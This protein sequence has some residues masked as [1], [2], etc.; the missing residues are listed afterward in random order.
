MN[1]EGD[2]RGI[3]ARIDSRGYKAYQDIKG[4]YR[5]EAFDLF[6]DHVQGD[7]FAAPSR[8][9]ARVSLDRAGFP[10]ILH[11]K[12]IRKI[13]FVDYIARQFRRALRGVVKGQRGMGK[14]G[15]IDI[16]DGGQEILERN[17]VVLDDHWLEARFVV[18]LP[19]MGRTILGR[20][21]MD[22]FFREVPLLVDRALFYRN[23]DSSGV[24][25]HVDAAEDQEYLRGTLPQKGLVAFIGDGA[26]LPR[27]SGVDD[28]PLERNAIPFR[29]PQELEVE[30]ELPNRGRIVGMGIPEGVT[31]IVGG[32]FHGKSTLLNAI[33]RGVYNHIPGDG[34]EVV[35]T[36]PGAVK[37]RAEDGRNIEKVNISAFINNLPLGKDTVKFS[38]ENASGSTS[39][40]ANIIEFLEMGA[41]V[42]LIDEDTSATNFMVRDE[43][44]QELVAK[45]KEPI[46]P[47]VDKVQRLCRDL[48]VSTILVMGGSG[49]YF[50]VADTVIMMDGYMPGCVTQ[51]AKE[52]AERHTTK[53]I[54]EGG[55]TFGTVTP[56]R[57]RIE[58]FDP[59]KGRKEVKIDAKGL[60]TILYGRTAID[61]SY[62]EQLVDRGQTRSIG[63][64]IH[65]YAQHYIHEGLPLREGL[66][67][68]FQDMKEKGLDMLLPY[69][70]GNLARPRIY[71]VAGATNRMRTLR[72]H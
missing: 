62:L 24:K 12:G 4:G 65:Y 29:Y 22:I 21:A 3:L 72:I 11:N 68:C 64:L 5:F 66:E 28:R 38:T 10:P 37:I 52:I 67:R 7:P 1:T 14:S 35:I 57:P 41:K 19:A 33:E 42:L 40:A 45:E 71:E 39:Q 9:R 53:R 6:I 27:R 47:F 49:D 31:L 70:V 58:S 13:A 18:G 16:D 8:V 25:G 54:D 61:L 48:K 23:Y 46:T 2:L 50:D 17:A 32:G 51:R 30:V 59:S 55:T 60:R 36:H 15:L 44:M 56:R 69:R 63:L 26:I 20:E 43:R 34:R